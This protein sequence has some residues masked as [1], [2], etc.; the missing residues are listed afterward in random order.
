MAA[1]SKR[2]RMASILLE[3]DTPLSASDIYKAW[4]GKY[5]PTTRQIAQLLSRSAEF[6]ST[7]TDPTL[8]PSGSKRVKSW[9]HADHSLLNPSEEE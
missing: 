5:R 1:V 8:Y 2:N 3:S 7:G 4:P 6:V 9:T